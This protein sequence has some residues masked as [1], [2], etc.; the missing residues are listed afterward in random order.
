MNFL[1]MLLT[2]F[3]LFK[4]GSRIYQEIKELSPL[5]D[6][7]ED[8][9]VNQ[10]RD[11][12]FATL[13]GSVMTALSQGAAGG[14]LF[15]A[16]GVP[17]ALLWGAVMAFLS[18]IPVVG[19]FLVWMPAG[20]YL[21]LEGETTKGIIMWVLGAVVVSSIDNLLKPIFI[22]GKADMHAMLVFFS[23]FGGMKVFGFLGL[24]VGPLIVALFLTFMNLYKVEF[25]EIL[26]QK[27]L[28]QESKAIL[29]E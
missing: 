26:T 14:I 12:S 5:P 18:F 28:R 9:L 11:V 10:F 7:Y 3:Y 27:I 1:I 23:V 20:A 15:A 8:M 13:Y 2:M 17:G 4:D 29:M 21:L 16:L 25:K 22:K 6:E 19:A 24:V